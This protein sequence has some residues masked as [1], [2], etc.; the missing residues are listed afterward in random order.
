MT[1][2]QTSGVAEITKLKSKYCVV[3]PNDDSSMEF[4]VNIC[5][6]IFNK[7][8]AKAE[9]ITLEVH[10]KGKGVA[11]IYSYEVAEQ[12]VETVT[13]ARRNGLDVT[14]EKTE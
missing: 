2:T 1:R 9:A 11:G 14:L 8:K 4:V 10:K 6:T 13:E 3:L 5:Q 7:T 12:N